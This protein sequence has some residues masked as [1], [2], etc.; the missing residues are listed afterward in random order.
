MKEDRMYFS[1]VLFHYTIN[2]WAYICIAFGIAYNRKPIYYYIIFRIMAQ[3]NIQIYV[4]VNCICMYG[5]YV[6]TGM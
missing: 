6:H 5:M 2:A 1:Y 3:L 4:C